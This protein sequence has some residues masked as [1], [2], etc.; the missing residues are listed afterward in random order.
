MNNFDNRRDPTRPLPPAFTK[1][2]P[3]VDIMERQAA[4]QAKGGLAT[5]MLYARLDAIRG[6]KGRKADAG[7]A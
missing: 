2:T 4:R 7:A 3:P 1:L 6:T 5:P